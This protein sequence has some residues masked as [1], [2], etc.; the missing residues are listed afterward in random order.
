[1]K[2]FNVLIN[3]FFPNKCISCGEIIEREE[4]LCEYC[5]E[6]I[7]NTDLLKICVGC[8][9]PKK[10][11]QCKL[12]V[13]HYAGV[14]APFENDGKAQSAMY[15]YKFKKVLTASEYFANEMAKSIKMV[16]N[17]IAFDAI[18]YVPMHPIKQLRRGFN[19]SEVL[20]GRLSELLNLKLYNSLLKAK[21]QR[22]SQH[23]L[24]FKE[25]F[26]SVKGI[27]SC[28]YDVTGKTILLVDDIKTTGATLDECAK[29]LLLSGADNV[30]CVC[31][32]ITKSKKGKK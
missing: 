14:I 9:L 11:C 8:G 29:Q 32:L 17:D 16:Y 31:G 30:Y 27:F 25:R 10:E 15:R 21:Y 23:N 19:Q 24:D 26:K 6:M 4:F 7:E 2:A 22:T 5:L 12:K 18:T 3:T 20:A 1:M 28:N 13:F